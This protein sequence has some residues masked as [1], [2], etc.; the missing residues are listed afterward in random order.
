[1]RSVKFVL[2]AKHRNLP[3]F[4]RNIVDVSWLALFFDSEKRSNIF[5]RN[6]DK[7]VSHYMVSHPRKQYSLNNIIWY[8]SVLQRRIQITVLNKYEI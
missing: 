6:M 5:S 4:R 2:L 1:M 7:L 8:R 3:A